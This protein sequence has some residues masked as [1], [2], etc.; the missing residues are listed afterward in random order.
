MHFGV[1]MRDGHRCPRKPYP[2]DA[3]DEEWAFVAPYLTML[4]SDAQQRRHDLREVYNALHWIVRAGSSWRMSPTNLPPWAA[5]HQQSQ[6]WIMAGCFGVTARDLR[7]MLRLAGG[8]A[9]EPTLDPTAMVFLDERSTPATLTPMRARAPR[10]ECVVGRVPGAVA[11]RHAAR[12]LRPHRD[13]RQPRRQRPGG[14]RRVRRLRRPAAGARPPPGADRRAGQPER[15]QE[16]PRPPRH[17]G[18]RVAPLL[19]ADVLPGL[20][21]RSSRRSPR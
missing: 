21:T 16:R 8:R 14:P 19:P 11:Q 13:G 4:N 6:R 2:S 17:R 1:A 7:A 9:P 10:G 3:T 20:S 5:V 15:R 12:Y 18:G